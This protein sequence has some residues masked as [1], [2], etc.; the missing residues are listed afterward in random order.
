MDTLLWVTGL[1][2]W[3][4]IAGIVVFIFGYE[5]VR[6]VV[7]SISWHRWALAEVKR[8]SVPFPWAALLKSFCFMWVELFGHRVGNQKWTTKLC[9]EWRGIGDWNVGTAMKVPGEEG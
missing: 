8:R 1:I 6:A 3:I 7:A 9:A 5:A 2:V 4:V